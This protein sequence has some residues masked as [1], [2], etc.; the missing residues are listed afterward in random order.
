MKRTNQE[1]DILRF[2]RERNK[3]NMKKYARLSFYEN[4]SGLIDQYS[5]TRYGYMC[6]SSVLVANDGGFM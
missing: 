5:I 2:K 1:D 6:R 4:V 3:A